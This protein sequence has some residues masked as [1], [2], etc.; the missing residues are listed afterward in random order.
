MAPDLDASIDR[1]LGAVLGYIPRSYDE[2]RPA[3]FYA[4]ISFGRQGSTMLRVDI[5][6]VNGLEVGVA[7]PDNP[8]GG[9]VLPVRPYQEDFVRRT[10]KGTWGVDVNRFANHGVRFA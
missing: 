5:V 3:G 1:V 10:I 8:L 2:S 4:P 6:E 9:P 7:T